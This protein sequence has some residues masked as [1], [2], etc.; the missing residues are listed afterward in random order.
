MKIDE[1]NKSFHFSLR[2]KIKKCVEAKHG[3]GIV[4]CWGSQESDKEKGIIFNQRNQNC[5]AFKI[6]FYSHAHVRTI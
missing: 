2:M 5:G 4:L 6:G 3:G 1:V